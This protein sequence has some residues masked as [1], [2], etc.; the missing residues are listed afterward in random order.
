MLAT[1]PSCQPGDTLRVLISCLQH[2]ACLILPHACTVCHRYTNTSA[3]ISHISYIDGD[4]GILRYRCAHQ[5]G[6]WS[7]L[8]LLLQ[9]PQLRQSALRTESASPC[10]LTACK[11]ASS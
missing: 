1:G 9:A 11:L 2:P 3:V 6:V 7:C 4:K 10:D 8:V 5:Q